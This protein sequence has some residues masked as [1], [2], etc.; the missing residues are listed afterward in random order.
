VH[1]TLALLLS[2]LLCVPWTGYG[3]LRA[4]LGLL[5]SSALIYSLAVLRR[6]RRQRSYVPEFEDWLWHVLLPVAAY[7]AVVAAAVSLDAEGSGP[8]FA[9]AAATLVL[10]CVGIHNAW[11]TVTYLTLSAMRS[12]LPSPAAPPQ[13]PVPASRRRR[14]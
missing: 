1:F 13:R 14:R 5:G 6:A 11:D 7:G 10:L 8:F 9:V 3:S 12:R 2:A 4:S